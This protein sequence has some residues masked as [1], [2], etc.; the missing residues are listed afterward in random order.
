[1]Y[2]RLTKFIKDCNILYEQQYGLRNKHSTQHAI[3]DIV[4]TILQEMDNGKFPY[5][6]FIDLKKAF[7]TVNMKFC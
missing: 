7:D 6:V 1:M 4:D 3:L 5:G 2:S